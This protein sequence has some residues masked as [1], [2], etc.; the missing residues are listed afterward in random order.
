MSVVGAWVAAVILRGRALALLGAVLA[1]ALGATLLAPSPALAGEIEVARLATRTDDPRALTF[2]ARVNAPAGLASARLEYSVQNPDGNIGGGGEAPVGEGTQQDLIF[3]LETITAQRYI[4]VGSEFTYR[5]TI[6]DREGT[7]LVT[8]EERF[9]FLDGRYSWQQRSRGLVT[10]YWYGPS[11]AAANL[12]LEATAN[13]LRDSEELLEASVPYPVKVMVWRSESEGELAMRPRGGIFDATV[14]TGG[15]RVAPDLLFV[16][17]PSRDVIRHEA[18]HIVTKVAGDGPFTQVPSWL[19]EGTA[20]YM[21]P[22]PGFGYNAALLSGIRGDRT[23]TLR[24]LTSPPGA[25]GRVDL[26]YGQS[27]SVVSYMLDVYGQPAFAEL[28]ATVKAGNLIDDALEAVYGFDQDGLYNEWRAANGLAPIEVAVRPGTS[29]PPV[30]EA[31]VPPLSIPGS[32]PV[33]GATTPATPAPD[34]AAG[35]PPPAATAGA[36]ADA[37][38][39]ADGGSAGSA[40]VLAGVTALLV[41]ALGGGAVAL[42]RRPGGSR[43]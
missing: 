30:V 15:Q 35:G 3:T 17:Q 10:V 38:A 2:T 19:D 41:I 18:A 5:W 33:G 32:S 39:S 22:D 6:V 37:D 26:F 27:W 24:G 29:A 8:E 20:V 23:L 34:G 21:Q 11:D 9:V 14:I 40:L 25:P 16:F 36:D 43:W 31:T 1:A 42:L 12:A 28:Y 7:E 4:P 13:S